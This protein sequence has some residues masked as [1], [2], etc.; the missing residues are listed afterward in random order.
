MA[1]D[2]HDHSKCTMMKKEFFAW[3]PV[4]A[5]HMHTKYNVTVMSQ[6]TQN[7]PQ[8]IHDVVQS[9]TVPNTQLTPQQSAQH[10]A[11]LASNNLH[12]RA[13]PL[14]PPHN[15]QQ[16]QLVIDYSKPLYTQREA[17]HESVLINPKDLEMW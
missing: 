16:Q 2:F 15:K 5:V 14:S 7:T 4:S 9:I 17:L 8:K 12:I 1:L 11:Q 10:K 6:L 3:N 13:K